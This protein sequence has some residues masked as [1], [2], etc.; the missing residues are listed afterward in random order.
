MK[1]LPSNLQ[2]EL[3]LRK[4]A[5]ESAKE[6]RK[7]AKQAYKAQVKAFKNRLKPFKQSFKQALLMEQ[8]AIAAYK[9][10][11]KTLKKT[12]G[13][14][15]Q[16]MELAQPT[17]SS[18]EIVSRSVATPSADT[19]DDLTR[20][21]GVGENVAKALNAADIYSYAQ[22]AATSIERYRQIL[23]EAN[24]SRF[25]NPLTWAKQAEALIAASPAPQKK[26]NRPGPKKAAAPKAPAAKPKKSSEP[27]KHTA[28]T[29]DDLT[30][31]KGIGEKVAEVLRAYGIT[32]FAAMAITPVERFKDI[33]RKNNMSKYR[34][35]SRW[36]E[37][38][39]A[40]AGGVAPA[41]IP[42]KKSAP[43]K[44]T[45]KKTAAKTKAPAAP[46]KT[47]AKKTTDNGTPARVDDLTQI[48]GVGDTIVGALNASGI[49][50]LA[51]VA[52]TSFE[53]FKEILRENNMSKYRNPATWAA[54]AKALLDMQKGSKSK[55]KKAKSS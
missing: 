23:K 12:A 54:Q 34:N 31:V 15:L 20:V 25:R 43:A 22:M 52:A 19:P 6:A 44:S 21:R 40:L 32:S 53:R 24:M 5:M 39:A 18:P 10:L 50:T 7:I 33:L 46:K 38:A 41:K 49:N 28:S 36:A 11:L 29:E 37:E 35:P 30:R 48:K 8:E 17:A 2:E 26:R 16:V 55:S 4:A 1:N 9:G 27:V 47:A 3:M 51:D 13:E 45:A 14:K 42:A